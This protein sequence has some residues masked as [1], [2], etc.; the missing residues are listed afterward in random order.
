M[1]TDVNPSVI[2]TPDFAP[3]AARFIAD[4][5]HAAITERGVFRLSLSG[6]N[7]PRPVHEALA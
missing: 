4:A 3:Y 5:A 6:G 1:Q 2:H 7:T